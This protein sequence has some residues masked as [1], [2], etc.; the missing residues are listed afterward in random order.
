MIPHLPRD[1][2][3]AEENGTDGPH[4][5]IVQEIQIVSAQIK[6][7][8]TQQYQQDD[9]YGSRIIWGSKNTNLKKIKYYNKI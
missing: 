7:S 6:E 4:L 9:G 5:L 1:H 2:N 3:E 8:G